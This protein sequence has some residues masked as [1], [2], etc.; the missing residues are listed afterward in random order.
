MATSYT[1]TAGFMGIGKTNPNYAVDAAGSLNVSGTVLVNGVPISL[2]SNPTGATGA[3]GK[4]GATG[5]SGGGTGPPA[6]RG[7][8]SVLSQTAAGT[9]TLSPATPTLIEWPTVDILQCTGYTGLL[10]AAGLFTN[11]SYV[12]IPVLVEYSLFLDATGYGSSYIAVNGPANAYA[13]MYNDVNAFTNSYTV[14]IPS[15]ATLGI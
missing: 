5:L 7:P 4:E 15:G 3:A 1:T 10:Y 12:T 14:L 13:V 9:Q 11:T 2:L 6:P 8:V